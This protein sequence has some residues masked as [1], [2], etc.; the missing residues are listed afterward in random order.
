M[1]PKIL[2]LFLRLFDFLQK[3]TKNLDYLI[4]SAN[5]LEKLPF[6]TFFAE[7]MFQ[8]PALLS[9]L[10][11]QILSSY[12][13]KLSLITHSAFPSA[14]IF[15]CHTRHLA[16]SPWWFLVFIPIDGLGRSSRGGVEVEGRGCAP[17]RFL[18]N[19]ILC[20]SRRIFFSKVSFMFFEGQ[21]EGGCTFD[22]ACIFS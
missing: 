20:V 12:E 17:N 3:N 14:S 16:Y 5:F 1:K 21:K 10:T 13:S 2:F 8:T 19:L 4:Y 11:L 22:C 15:I 18:K 9:L 7:T 6:S